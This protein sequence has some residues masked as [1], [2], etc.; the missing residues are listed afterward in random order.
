MLRLLLKDKLPK[1][2]LCFVPRG[3]EV[4]GDI[5]IIK[6]PSCLEKEKYL[7]AEALISNRK[8]IKV[9]L[10]KTKKIH[11]EHRVGGFE[12]LIGDRTYTYHKE[13]NCI[14]YVDITKAYFS[15]KLGYERMRIARK[16]KEGEHVLVPFCGVGTF[17]IPI[18][19]HKN[20]SIVGLDNNYFACKYLKKNLELNNIHAEVILGD[21]NFINNTFRRRFDRVVMPTPYGKDHFLMLAKKLLKPEGVV[22]F[23]TFKKDE[24]LGY[25]KRML[26]ARGW[27]IEFYRACGNVAPRVKRYVFDLRKT[28]VLL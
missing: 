3:F 7:I 10:R 15:S 14:F 19:K 21:A 20:V 28:N 16:V 13:N 26:E 27:I 23:Y 6:I 18:K 5:A 25:F 2:K 12:L 24:E 17:L 9:V 11:G 22:H 8:D 4:V 1:E